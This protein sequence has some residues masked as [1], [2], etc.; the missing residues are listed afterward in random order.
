ME[1]TDN[2]GCK[3]QIQTNKDNIKTI[4]NR[5]YQVGILTIINMLTA[6]VYLVGVFLN[7]KN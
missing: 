3:V 6:I 7:G 1:C 5:M 2:C 4:S